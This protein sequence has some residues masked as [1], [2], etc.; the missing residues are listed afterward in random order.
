[1]TDIDCVLSSDLSRCLAVARPVATKLNKSL[2][3]L[4]ELRELDF[5]EWEGLTFGE[6]AERYPEEQAKWLDDPYQVGP[7]GGETLQQ[8]QE[9]IR[10]ALTAYEQH[11]VIIVTH[12]GVLAT[13]Q[14]LWLGKN[15]WLPETGT[16]LAIDLQQKDGSF[17]AY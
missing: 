12:G 17:I 10:Q 5:G 1:M 2:Y 15:F 11:N 6:I 13:V 16:C 14:S 3:V 9:R 4:A 8:M 7:P